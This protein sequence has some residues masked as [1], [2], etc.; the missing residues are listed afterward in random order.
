M[1]PRASSAKAI[2]GHPSPATRTI[3]SASTSPAST[4]GPNADRARRLIGDGDRRRLAVEH[5]VELAVD[6]AHRLVVVLAPRLVDAHRIE[7]LRPRLVA[8]VEERDQILRG[9]LAHAVPVRR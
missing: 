5:V 2:Y 4:W 9:R 3:R 1:F 7:Q 8:A 6:A